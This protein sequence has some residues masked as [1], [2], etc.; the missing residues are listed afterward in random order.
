MM[1][2][3][4]RQEKVFISFLLFAILVGAGVKIYRSFSI[5]APQLIRPNDVVK[6]EQQIQDKAALI[7]SLLE[8]RT[9]SFTAANFIDHEV[10]S[11][12]FDSARK[13]NKSSLLLE[14][15]SATA[16]ELVQLPQ[17]GLVLAERIVEYRNSYGA[18]KNI[19]ELTKVK[20]IGERKI[21]L[22]KPYIYIE[23]KK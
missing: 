1:D 15:N 3:F 22:I 14:I 18:F 9:L 21:N 10:K 12:S 2:L 19:D 5:T 20:G 4:T 23:Q 13:L 6:T 7:D 11:K 17:I 16:A 8:L